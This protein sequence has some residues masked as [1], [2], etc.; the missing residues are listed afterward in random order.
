[1]ARSRLRK[2]ARAAKRI[3][4]VSIPP[5]NPPMI[6]PVLVRRWVWVKLADVVAEARGV[7]SDVEDEVDDSDFVDETEDC[8]WPLENVRVKAE[9]V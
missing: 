8:D 5:S 3:I 7:S 6:A 2:Q 4:S 9:E 1:M